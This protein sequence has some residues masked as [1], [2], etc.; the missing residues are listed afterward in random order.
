MR[1]ALV[2]GDGLPTSGLLTVFRNVLDVGRDLGLVDLPVATDLGYAWRPDKAEYFPAGGRRP[3]DSGWMRT[4]RRRVRDGMTDAERA[5]ELLSIRDQVAAHGS[6][7]DAAR[8]ELSSRIDRLSDAY[9]AYFAEWLAEH[10]PDWIFGLNMTLSDAV[11]ATA[12]LHAAVR[13]HFAGGRRGG[14]VFWD[15]D[16]F[17]SCAIHDEETGARV[18]PERPY[19]LTPLPRDDAHTRWIVISD[20]LAEEAAGYPTDAVPEVV[21][22]LLPSV[23]EGRLE[24]R[25]REF[26]AQHGLDAERPVLL[27]PVRVFRIKG[28]DVAVRLLAEMKDAAG[29]A[30]EPVPYLLVFG[31][32][33]EDPE[34]AGEVTALAARAGVEDDI[35]FLDGVP[36]T[37]FR[38]DEGGWHLDEVDLLRVA[39]ASS[40]GVV[41]T[42]G[43]TDV[44]TVGLGPGLAAMAGL[45]CLTTDYDVFEPVY[46]PEFSRVR[47]GVPPEAAR[48]GAAEFIRTLAAFRRGDDWLRGRL[49]VNRKIVEERFPRGPWTR[50]WRELESAAD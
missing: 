17:G 2:S 21:S 27:D 46:G 45:P 16:L 43:V 22:N 32:L 20:G 14:M 12:G 40:G 34:Y 11:P 1:I 37:S 42:P 24:A 7:D 31:G 41:F 38:D 44:E 9:R 15:H 23:P 39:A 33:D 19:D 3:A 5:E 6:L 29:A 4:T 13:D 35:R 47:T 26:A 36:L 50:F 18:Y 8:R 28:V 10:K 49:E 25:H 30:G 48:T